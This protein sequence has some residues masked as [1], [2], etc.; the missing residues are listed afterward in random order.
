MF[1]EGLW[2]AQ[3]ALDLLA[4]HLIDGAT[5]EASFGDAARLHEDMLSEGAR[6]HLEAHPPR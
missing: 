2:G 6:K 3:K 1:A 4:T 5:G